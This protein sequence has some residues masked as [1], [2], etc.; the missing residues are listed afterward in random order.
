MGRADSTG[1]RRVSGPALP[2]LESGPAGAD[3]IISRPARR[4]AKSGAYRPTTRPRNSDYGTW[5]NATALHR[6][7][8]VS[9]PR[10]RPRRP[11]RGAGPPPGSAPPAPPPSSG[12]PP[13]PARPAG[14]APPAGTA[15]SSSRSSPP[16]PSCPSR[17][18]P[19]PLHIPRHGSSDFG[20]I[21]TVAANWSTGT[22]FSP[23]RIRA[24]GERYRH[25]G[26]AP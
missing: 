26:D 8:R 14:R 4:R 7:G 16:W 9:P 23:I 1:G 20:K 19:M 25:S 22:H 13:P 12:C 5:T 10:P 3:F 6:R 15:P 11:A 2:H 17:Q 18:R 21:T 24:M